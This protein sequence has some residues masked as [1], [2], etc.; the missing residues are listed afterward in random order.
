MTDGPT[1]LEALAGVWRAADG[2]KGD[3]A[4]VSIEGA[5]PAYS[6]PF[7]V[8]TLAAASV[9]GAALAAA[10][11]WRAR[12]GRWQQA[13][14]S[15]RHAAAAFRSER[16]LRVEGAMAADLWDPFSGYYRTADDRW[17]QLH[18]N[19]PHHRERALRTLGLDAAK[20]TDRADAERAMLAW[21]GQAF[22]DALA[23]VGGC[24]YLART[25]QEWR[26]H[27]Q[28]RALA[29]L[30]PIDLGVI[31]QAPARTFAADASMP[32]S[33]IRVLDMSRVVAG[34]VA[35]RTLAAYGADVIRMGA[36]HLPEMAPLV[37]DTGFG[38]R[39][40]HLDLRTAS[41]R[42]RFEALVASVDVVVQ[43]YRPG[44]LDA[45]GYGPDDL[46][47]LR[48]GVV[49]VS[50]S[51]WSHEGPWAGRRGFDSL[52]QT[53]SGILLEG[54]EWARS[55]R[56]VPLP[57]QALDHATGYLAAMGAMLALARQVEEGGSRRVRVALAR[58]GT[59][60]DGLGR[61]DGSGVADT[62]AN[63]VRDLT[64]EMASDFGRLR[65]ITP[66]GGLDE[67]PPRW[68]R[69]PGRPGAEPRW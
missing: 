30:S 56:P 38:K 43:A 26:A 39:F 1:P 69:P 28:A 3:L 24:G 51:A 9:A 45:L 49:V 42:A 29:A 36:A 66:P 64:D 59:W 6:S 68:T 10:R 21:N 17:V 40:V 32:L 44:A 54:T 8:G 16:Y 62:T 31:G 27:P 19:F 37:I 35:G 12:T 60:L 41:D 2:D 61:V 53:A 55:E 48:P 25:P 11:V 14:V 13:S 63:D 22:E 4:H 20:T 46:A 58:T 57:A 23:E 50:L 65:F 5:D 34:P 52:V 18:T 47:R 67:T 15:M 7:R 33:G